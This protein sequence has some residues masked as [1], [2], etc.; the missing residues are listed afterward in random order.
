MGIFDLLRKT[1]SALRLEDEVYLAYLYGHRIDEHE[2]LRSRACKWPGLLLRCVLFFRFLQKNYR[3]N[4]K[5]SNNVDCL[6]YSGTDNQMK[7]LSQVIK[8][9]HKKGMAVAIFHGETVSCDYI[10]S[11]INVRP[12]YFRIKEITVASV[13]FFIKAPSLYLR[14]RKRG[15]KIGVSH[16]FNIFCE[17]YVYLPYFFRILGETKPIFVIQS[18]DHN[19]SNRSLRLAS[20]LMGIKT[21][22]MQH[23][24]GTGFQPPLDFDYA[25]L[26]GEQAMKAY[27]YK[28]ITLS[29]G[30]NKHPKSFNTTIFL[31][32]QKKYLTRGKSAQAYLEKEFCVG[33]GVSSLN[34]FSLLKSLLE[35]LKIKN[36]KCIVRAHPGQ[37]AVFL[38]ELRD[39]I[40]NNENVLFSD[41]KK[42]QLTE[43]FSQCN[44]LI[45]ANTSLHLD[46]G[47]VGIPSYYYELSDHA[48]QPDYFGFEK[49]GLLEYFPENIYC[50]SDSE[51]K[52]LAVQSK[53]RLSAIRYYSESF[54][55][56]WEGREGELVAETLYRMKCNS[57]LENIFI[58]ESHTKCFKGIY[59]LM[60]N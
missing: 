34:E 15:N 7:S 38:S 24:A 49:A 8:A 37:S 1:L 47:L 56:P 21:V 23:G 52:G 19:I 27:G 25:F 45:A 35:K 10:D 18:N 17:S 60:N 44:I 12:V 33:I 4:E 31:S 46:A 50:M 42:I 16:Y 30:E 32:G 54:N 13:L 48:L 14:L 55:T 9:L 51:I 59:R 41:P 22:F 3:N 2:Y 40:E 6:V 39:Y 36:I 20:Q 29:S 53:K 57:S 11:A 28:Y 58:K 26:N 43:F 5:S